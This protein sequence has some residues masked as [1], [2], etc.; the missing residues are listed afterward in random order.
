MKT[1]CRFE[2]TVLLSIL[3]LFSSAAAFSDSL[4]ILMPSR[5]NLPSW[6]LDSLRKRLEKTL[7]HEVTLHLR[8]VASD[9]G[10][11][12]VA[13]VPLLLI[14]EGT[15]LASVTSSLRPTPVTL[16][17]FWMLG[18]RIDL[19]SP[20]ASAPPRTMSEFN[21]LLEQLGKR[22]PER[23]PWFESLESPMTLYRLKQ[24]LRRD[25]PDSAAQLLQLALDRKWLNPFSLESDESLAYEVFEAGD[26]VFASLWVPGE[27]IASM[28]GRLDRKIIFSP[29]PGESGPTPVPHVTLRLWADRDDSR[30]SRTYQPAF[31]LAPDLLEAV[32]LPCNIP[33]ERLWVRRDSSRF[34]NRLIEGEP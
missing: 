28:P 6:I 8:P 2:L 19:L 18:T 11:V 25:S 33:A 31:P 4:R 34:F 26:A 14:E 22:H 3:F 12:D 10:P 13:S 29:F 7:S 23:F 21:V 20:L 15:N 27:A 30:W 17:L 24:A 16:D 5:L 32:F 1:G 9:L